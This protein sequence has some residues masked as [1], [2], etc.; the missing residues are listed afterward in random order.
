MNLNK[1]LILFLL[2]IKPLT[3]GNDFFYLNDKSKYVIAL[4]KSNGFKPNKRIIKSIIYASE[5]F[6]IDPLELTAIAIIESGI[7]KYTKTRINKNGTKDVGLFQINTVNKEFCIEYN[8]ENPEGSSLCAAKLLANLKVK[9]SD[10]LGAY[11]SKTPSLKYIYIKK[12]K[13]V[14]SKL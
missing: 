3:V 12:I 8:L 13:N 9:R 6:H 4:S 10:Y 5:M 14:L 1:F 2:F 11:H 7:G